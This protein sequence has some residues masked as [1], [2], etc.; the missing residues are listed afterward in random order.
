M[1]AQPLQQAQNSEELMINMDKI[2]QLKEEI[3]QHMEEAIKNSNLPDF[4]AR[5]GLIEKT[6]RIEVMLDLNQIRNTDYIKEQELKDAL[7]EIPG[8]ELSIRCCYPCAG[9]WCRC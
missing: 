1:T 2:K 7:R 8:K 6:L 9:G 4:F 3:D 5:K